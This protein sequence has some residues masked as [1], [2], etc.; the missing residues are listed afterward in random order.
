MPKRNSSNT[1]LP[2]PL[3]NK[4][5]TDEEVSDEDEGE[6]FDVADTHA[7]N[8]EQRRVR[9]VR[10]STTVKPAIL[11]RNEALAAAA[12]AEH[13]AS[14][15]A[16]LLA[17]SPNPTGTS[18]TES[19]VSS[20]GGNRHSSLV[21]DEGDDDFDHS[22]RAEHSPFTDKSRR[23]GREQWEEYRLY[24]S[25]Y[26][27]TNKAA[28]NLGPGSGVGAS[29]LAISDPIGD[30][31]LVQKGS[32][33]AT[34]DIP[35]DDV[36][37]SR[38]SNYSV[39]G[40]GMKRFQHI[41]P[42][43]GIYMVAPERDETSLR[44][45]LR[46][47]HT[48][49]LLVPVQLFMFAW[50]LI[51]VAFLI[52]DF[53]TN[54]V[55]YE[56]V[57]MFAASLFFFEMSC[58][59]AYLRLHFF[60]LDR[61]W[62]VAEVAIVT[63]TFAL[64]VAIQVM[65]GV[66][67]VEAKLRYFRALRFLRAIILMKTRSRYFNSALRRLISADRRRYHQNGFD[68]DLT[69]VY[70]HIVATSWPS[71]SVESLYRNHI[72]TVA[73]FLDHS[74]GSNYWV[75]NL[76]SERSYDE[77]KFHNRVTRYLLDDH[78]PTDLWTMVVFARDVHAFMKRNPEEN[79]AV[80]HC[81]GGK[82]R[83]GTMICAY[84][85][86]SELQSAADDAMGFFGKQRTAASAAKFQG[87]ES[88][89]QGRYVRYF[90]RLLREVPRTELFATGVP[91]RKVRISKLIVRSVPAMLLT[92][93]IDRLWFA[94]VSKPG[95]DREVHYVS[96]PTVYFD[97]RPPLK[98]GGRG[99]GGSPRDPS[100]TGSRGNSASRNGE[101]T[102]LMAGS[103]MRKSKAEMGP[104]S[105]AKEG[106]SD[107]ANGCKPY[108]GNMV[109]YVNGDTDTPYDADTFHDTFLQS[110][111]ETGVDATE[112][113]PR[114]SNTSRS[115][116]RGT[117]WETASSTSSKAFSSPTKSSSFFRNDAPHYRGDIAGTVDVA[118]NVSAI[119][120]ISEDAVVKFFYNVD[121]PNCLHPAFQ[122]WFHPY[123][124]EEGMNLSKKEID[125][126]HKE[127]YKEKKFK[128]SFAIEVAFEDCEE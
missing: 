78:N 2:P 98:G 119:P 71:A 128:N 99:V 16:P 113:S 50:L 6:T 5:N 21:D 70:R 117:D 14:T 75:Y 26:S 66:N 69:Y 72:D 88:P 110:R 28:S 95:S 106:V 57:N 36:R 13:S 65:D 20:N 60:A 74:H 127:G 15:S 103:P 86:Y 9:E 24:E 91:T 61:W 92:R 12:A 90:E 84:M 79:V 7:R 18:R 123:F 80:V 62:Q 126:P 53:S 108:S 87:V 100:Q 116:D 3:P 102:D 112:S 39:K 81:K 107:L 76:C 29:S 83:T 82:G 111:R 43:T 35:H 118:F 1:S 17:H 45:A 59:L 85:L 55:R 73:A 23:N 4:S 34:V 51:D 41:N 96:N 47:I 58:H 46:L 68:L 22:P 121:N 115:P 105:L 44:R 56:P 32:N 49:W 77:S 97:P 124:E 63:V 33:V 67:E 31:L 120:P 10:R 37:S 52:Y 125:G 8:E 48:F 11:R 94:V 109:L 122:F 64:E 104:S 30:D 93:G 25:V 40:G 42:Y 114:F 27:A 19:H 54:D 38:V 101:V 89:S